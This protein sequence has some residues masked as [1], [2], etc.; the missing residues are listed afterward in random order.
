MSADADLHVEVVLRSDLATV[1]LRRA[2]ELIPDMLEDGDGEYDVVA[3][4]WLD[5]F[6]R[7][8]NG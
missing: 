4:E 3:Q 8:S 6:R 5:D 7:L 2:A 1:L